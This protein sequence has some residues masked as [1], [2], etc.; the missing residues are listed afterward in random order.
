MVVTHHVML[1]SYVCIYNVIQS[2]STKLEQKHT[3]Y[4]TF[5]TLHDSFSRFLVFISFYIYL[6]ALPSGTHNHEKIIISVNYHHNL[7]CILCLLLLY[8]IYMIISCIFILK[9]VNNLL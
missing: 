3:E 7:F 6:H 2:F 5:V 4:N 8:T 1:F 9:V